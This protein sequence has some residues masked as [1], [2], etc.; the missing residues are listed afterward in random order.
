[1]YCPYIGYNFL[2][3]NDLLSFNLSGMLIYDGLIG[4]YTVQSALSLAYHIDYWSNT[5]SLNKTAVDF[6][7]NFT[8]YCQYSDYVDHYLT[9]P[10]PGPQPLIPPK[11]D[12]QGCQTDMLDEIFAAIY[13]VNPSWNVYQTS[14]LP[15][16]PDDPLNAFNPSDREP[17]FNRTDVKKAINA[18]DKEWVACGGRD[19]FGA[20]DIDVS[21][22]PITNTLPSVIERTQNVI[23]S[24][25]MNDFVLNAN[26][27]L[28]AIQNMSWGGQLGFQTQ[29][30]DPLFVPIHGGGPT[31]IPPDPSY[32]D[33]PRT[34][35]PSGVL[36]TTHTERGLTW[37]L[38]MNAGHLTPMFQAALAYRQVE[39]LLGRVSNMS[40]TYPFVISAN[41]STAGAPSQPRPDELGGPVGPILGRPAPQSASDNYP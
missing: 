32:P 33:S 12:D 27:T 7:Q 18:P 31:V 39:V 40:S 14:Q 4:E 21:D 24:H 8:S 15:P 2:N 29:P 6:I 16:I 1:M 22:P 19:V 20:G 13:L 34:T 38:V 3:Q 23:I 17:Y 26:G 9:F 30:N 37:N 35:P 10:P 25:A 11:H 41:G 5:L 36:G 28:L